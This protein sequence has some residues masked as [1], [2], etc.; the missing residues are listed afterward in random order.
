MLL[1]IYHA[2]LW[3]NGAWTI[4]RKD[5]PLETLFLPQQTPEEDDDE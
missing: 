1:R 3:G 5:T 2:A 4:K